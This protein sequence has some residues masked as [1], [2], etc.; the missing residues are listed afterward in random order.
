MGKKEEEEII[1]IAKKID[2]LAQKKTAVSCWHDWMNVS[3]VPDKAG[4]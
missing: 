4:G 2:K 3:S 1:R